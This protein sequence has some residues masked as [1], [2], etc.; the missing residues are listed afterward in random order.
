MTMTTHFEPE[1]D[2]KAQEEYFR[3]W[4]AHP[5]EE[6][7]FRWRNRL[8]L[9]RYRNFCW[10]HPWESFTVFRPEWVDRCFSEDVTPLWD[11]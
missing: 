5:Q 9:L 7:L 4:E 6:S 1:R 2:P 3:L 8:W 11:V 10:R